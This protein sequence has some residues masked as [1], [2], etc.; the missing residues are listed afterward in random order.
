M[1]K[2]NTSDCLFAIICTT[3]EGNTY[4]SNISSEK[5]VDFIKEIGEFKVYEDKIHGIKIEKN[6]R[7]L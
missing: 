7:N 5:I 3:P 6:D 2:F 1:E 4:Q